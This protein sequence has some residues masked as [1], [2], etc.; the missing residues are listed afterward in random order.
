MQLWIT[1]GLTV[2]LAAAAGLLV[3]AIQTALDLDDAKTIDPIPPEDP[4]QQKK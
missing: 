2:F 4:Q 3:Y 1:L